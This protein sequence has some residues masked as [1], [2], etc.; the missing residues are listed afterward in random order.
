MKEASKTGATGFGQLN[1]KELE[2]LKNASTALK[3]DLPKEDAVRYI[4]DMKSAVQKIIDNK[5]GG[6]EGLSF[7]SE[8]E[9]SSANLKPGTK[10]TINGRP[11]VWE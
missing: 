1:V 4:N 10:I 7:S 6:D 3:K 8:E 2:T 11:A 9:A 5:E